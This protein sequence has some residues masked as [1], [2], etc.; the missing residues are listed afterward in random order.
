MHGDN[1]AIGNQTWAKAFFCFFLAHGT[2][3]ATQKF[4]QMLKNSGETFEKFK[5]SAQKVCI[6]E[7]ATHALMHTSFLRHFDR[8]THKFLQK[9]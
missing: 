2:F 5:T 4:A 7:K 1:A 6:Y 8:T 9:L 3:M